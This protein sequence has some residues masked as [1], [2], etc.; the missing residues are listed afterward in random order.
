MEH[1]KLMYCPAH[2]GIKENEIAANLVETASKESSHLPP[3]ADISLSKVKK[4][5][6]QIPLDKWHKTWENPYF[7]KSKQPILYIKLPIQDWQALPLYYQCTMFLTKYLSIMI[8][9]INY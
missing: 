5:N 8:G 7:H 3:E 6:R 2:K 4:I 1:I 9:T